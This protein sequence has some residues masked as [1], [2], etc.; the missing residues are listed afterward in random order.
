MIV[1]KPRPKPATINS[2]KGRDKI[3]KVGWTGESVSKKYSQK[4]KKTPKRT[5]NAINCEIMDAMGIVRRGK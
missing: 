4:T 3:H 1:P 2:K 5:K